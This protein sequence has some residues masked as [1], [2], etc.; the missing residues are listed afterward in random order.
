MD[1][2]KLEME[3]QN[4]Y[5]T[6]DLQ[7]LYRAYLSDFIKKNNHVGI[8]WGLDIRE[9]DAPYVRKKLLARV[10]AI[11]IC[12][13]NTLEQWLLELPPE[14][15]QIAGKI[16]WEGR[17]PVDNLERHIT[18]KILLSREKKRQS[19]SSSINPVFCWFQIEQDN[20]QN[21]ENRKRVYLDL[22]PVLRKELKKYFPPPIGYRL[23]PIPLPETSYL[24][25]DNETILSRLLLICSIFDDGEIVAKKSGRLTQK[26]IRF[27]QHIVSLPEFYRNSND[28]KLQNI[29]LQLINHM[30]KIVELPKRRENPITVLKEI[31]NSYCNI[32]QFPH[33]QL[34]DHVTGWQYVSDWRKSDIHTRFV[35]IIREFP[36]REWIEVSQLL[37]YAVLRE[38]PLNP[39]S[40]EQAKHYLRIP[41]DWTGWG[42]TL[43]SIS[44]DYFI[45]AITAPIVKALI[46]LFAAFGLLD[47]A[48]E[49]PFNKELKFKDKSYLTA[50]DGVL[51]ARLTRLGAYILGKTDIYT[52]TFKTGKKAE[53]ILDQDHLHFYLTAVD[54]LIEYRVEDV[55]KRIG[56]QRY[57]VD[58]STFLRNCAS[59][60]DV[61][62]KLTWFKKLIGDNI[63]D[64]WSRFFEQLLTRTNAFELK[65]DVIVYKIVSENKEL[66]HFLM[67]DEVISRYI[68]KAENYHIVLSK[69]DLAKVKKRSKDFGFLL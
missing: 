17:Q 69:K 59:R 20:I 27:I 46:S 41:A 43:D 67:T 6:S 24:F 52:G 63:P 30:L 16:A 66:M 9:L 65:S 11:I 26:S 25:E 55:A 3:I 7:E 29:R 38:I 49:L 21:D 40:V 58:F 8:E 44:Q 37:R 42:N 64:N 13:K 36:T 57:T 1:L 23:K 48:Y 47:I 31:L 10:F 19:I 68:N 35:Q 45:S 34:L 5:T 62:R 18:T 28:E 53:I 32:N 39:V 56:R 14:V 15:I 54:P 61:K 33:T 22:P 2:L 12:E 50:Y 60:S 4:A 51:Y